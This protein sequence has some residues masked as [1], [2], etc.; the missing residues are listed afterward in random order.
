MRSIVHLFWKLQS[1]SHASPVMKPLLPPSPLMADQL[2]VI[3][4]SPRTRLVNRCDSPYRQQTGFR[5]RITRAGTGRGSNGC[6]MH[7]VIIDTGS[8][9]GVA[10]GVSGNGRLGLLLIGFTPLIHSGPTLLDAICPPCISGTSARLPENA[11]T[12]DVDD[13]IK[14]SIFLA[15]LHRTQRLGGHQ[16]EH[17]TVVGR[18]KSVHHV[19]KR[20]EFSDPSATHMALH[21]GAVVPPFPT[22][23][24]SLRDAW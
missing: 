24:S 21:F 22:L 11:H 2:A 13:P 20:I 3:K 19:H 1:I 16:A 10:I 17:L 8:T 23:G 9:G 4:E 12:F 14:L 15:G 5:P 7:R 6:Q 18:G